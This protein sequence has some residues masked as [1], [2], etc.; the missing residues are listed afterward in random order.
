M[1]K[2]LTKG[3]RSFDVISLQQLINK[4]GASLGIR[5]SP[6]GDFGAKT[7]E[8]L[9]MVQKKIGVTTSGVA[10]LVT[11]KALY[12]E[13]GINQLGL[14]NFVYAGMGIDQY[15]P[16]HV[17][18]DIIVLH[19]TAGSA[20]PF[21]TRDHWHKNMSRVGTCYIVGGKGKYD[22][23]MVQVYE[24]PSQWA[25][26]LNIWGNFNVYGKQKEANKSHETRMAKRTIAI[27]VCN[28]GYLKYIDGS[29]WFMS[30]G[31][32]AYEVPKEEVIDYGDKGYRNKRFYHRYTNKQIEATYDFITKAA[33]YY[34]IN[35]DKPEG[36]FD[37]RWFDYSWDATRGEQNLISH[38]SVRSKSDMHPQPELIDMLNSL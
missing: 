11:T 1:Y 25:Y 20:N 33:E 21:Y 30:R 23:V 17:N 38:S 29:F 22:G 3:A 12:K 27:E 14:K 18:K 32:K 10:D 5:L 35:L 9:R 26:H 24:H 8:A 6:D 7:K 15:F 13:T 2:T 19:H 31:K 37:K 16:E 34:H 36:G 4:A 28:W